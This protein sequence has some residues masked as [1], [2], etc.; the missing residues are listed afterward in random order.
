MSDEITVTKGTT[1]GGAMQREADSQAASQT[2]PTTEIPTTTTQEPTIAVDTQGQL[3]ETQ[4]Q[5]TPTETAPTPTETTT[6]EEQ[7]DTSPVVSFDVLDTTKEDTAPVVLGTWEDQIKNADINKVAEV[8]GLDPFV[9]ELN[10]HLKNGG[11]A[12]DYLAAKAIDYN[13]VSDADLLK[14]EFASKYPHLDPSEQ[15]YLFNK[16]YGISEFDD[17]DVQR[18]KS[19]ALKAD[20]YEVRQK[21]IAEQANFKIPEPLKQNQTIDEEALRVQQAEIQKETQ[22]LQFIQNH[23]VTK[24]LFA[25]KRVVVDLGEGVPPFNFALDKPEAIMQIFSDGELW[26]KALS[27]KTGE[28][29]VAKMQRIALAAL[30][31][32]YEKS[33]VDYGKTLEK[34]RAAL[35][36]KNAKKPTGA[37]PSTT[38]TEVRVTKTNGT[39]GSYIR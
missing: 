35:E 12:V 31:P 25:N 18:D 6:V 19:I 28:P 10:K 13:K 2:V 26:E 4:T 14:K 20:A 22:K 21:K 23:E 33:L 8:L 5:T 32:N 9:L 38:D 16:K 30:N 36:D 3:T 39:F 24:N 15:E 7:F 17:E 27:T 34:R 29:D 1:F 37:M 11:S